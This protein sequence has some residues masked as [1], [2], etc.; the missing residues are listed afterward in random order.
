MTKIEAHFEK[1]PNGG[2]ASTTNSGNFGDD[3]FSAEI[4]NGTATYDGTVAMHGTTSLRY[5]TGSTGDGYAAF[6]F[7]QFDA[8][9]AVVRFYLRLAGLATGT[10]AVTAICEFRSDDSATL[11]SIHLQPSGKLSL[12]DAGT[13]STLYTTTVALV[14]NRWYRI[15]HGLKLGTGSGQSKFAVYD[16]DAT[17]AALSSYDSGATLTTP[18]GKTIN[19]S[20]VGKLFGVSGSVQP[21]IWVDD[22]A[23]QDGTM[24]YLGPYSPGPVII[25][26]PNQGIAV[27]DCTQ[28]YVG[29]NGDTLTYSISPTGSGISQPA[30]GIFFV[31]E[32]PNATNYQ[33]TATESN[34]KTDTTTVTVPGQLPGGLGFQTKRYVGGTWVH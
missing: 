11:S 10:P 19:S 33:I 30:P 25:A 18:A 7:G 8:T 16:G 4:L 28:S 5:D 9:Q 3:P 26:K 29:V 22:W 6:Y 1:H 17:T 24:T 27:I 21:A 20:V 34:G 12:L 13:G 31:P 23:V 32:T 14:A 2:L 15:E